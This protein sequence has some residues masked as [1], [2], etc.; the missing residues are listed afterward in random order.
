MKKAKIMLMAIAILGLVGGALAFKSAK[1]FTGKYYCLTTTAVGGPTTWITTYTTVPQV[2]KCTEG[3]TSITTIPNTN[4]SGLL[5][6]T[7]YYG[8]GVTTTVYAAAGE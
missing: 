4:P 6:N 3:F 1:F 8:V 2:V 5:V 7:T